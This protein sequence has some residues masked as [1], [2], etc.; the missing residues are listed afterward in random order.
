MD[1]LVKRGGI[2][3]E[4]RVGLVGAGAMASLIAMKLHERG[5]SNVVIFNR[6]LENAR[7][8]ATR[9]GYDYEP[10]TR[11]AAAFQAWPP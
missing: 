6:T 9:L 1:Y 3:K 5:F 4:S 2:G 10:S 7:R 8:L 11:C